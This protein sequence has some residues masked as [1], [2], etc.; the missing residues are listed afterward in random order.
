MENNKNSKLTKWLESLQQES[1]QL[2]LIISGFAI[3]LVGSLGEPLD[4]WGNRM[5]VATSGVKNNFIMVLP[6]M[7]LYAAWFFLLTNLVLHL[8][9]R[10]LWISTIGL[11]YVSGDIDWDKLNLHP[12]FHN[13][14][15]SN[16]GSYDE[17]IERL[18]KLCSVVFAFTFMIIFI[19]ISFGLWF[20]ALAFILE[21]ILQGLLYPI[22]SESTYMIIKRVFSISLLATGLLYFIDFLTLGWL[23]RRK[24]ASKFYYPI[25]RFYSFIT[26]ASL[27]RPIYYNLI[28]HKYGRNLSKLLIPYIFILT[29]FA[30]F[31]VEHHAHYPTEN[32]DGN[33]LSRLNYDDE[34]ESLDSPIEKISLPS[35]YISNGFLDVFI[36]YKGG[37]D[38]ATVEML[39]PN[40]KP[41]REVGIQSD[42]IIGF[43]SNVNDDISSDSS[44][45]CVQNLYQISVD[46]SI[47][48]DL[49]ARFFRYPK[50]GERGLKTIIDVD[51]LPRGEHLL[52]VDFQKLTN[53]SLFWEKLDVVPFWKE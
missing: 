32:K 41:L 38:N 21:F 29:L 22:L 3:F 5:S 28:D 46:D 43:N 37:R 27:Y 15:Q 25:Y 13:Y 8:I 11:R 9:L 26:L 51:Y 12:K 2:E 50:Y 36:K 33:I 34:R 1:W 20:M 17:Y 19:F 47:F 30:S 10:G 7:I 48:T 24:W 40:L 31:N 4:D 45:I 35:K 23:K 53:D 49:N 39:C 14:L 16:I 42:F 52:R 18:E 44:L 6:L